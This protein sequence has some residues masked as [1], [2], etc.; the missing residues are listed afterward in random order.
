MF[1]LK[2]G[3]ISIL[4]LISALGEVIEMALKPELSDFF[5]NYNFDT[6]YRLTSDPREKIRF[7]AMIHLQEGKTFT[8]IGKNLKVDRHTVAEWLKRFEY[9]GVRGMGDKKRSGRNTTLPRSKEDRFKK[10]VAKLQEDREGGHVGGEDIRRM[11]KEVF[12][13]EY[14]LSG[15][16]DLLKRI[17]MVWITGRTVHPNAD[18]EAQNEFRDNFTEKAKDVLPADIDINKVDI[19]FQDEA[20]VGQRGT[21][22]RIWTEK[23]SRTGIV[24]Q[25]QFNSVYIFGAVCPLNDEAVG[26]VMPYADTSATETHLKIISQQVLEGRHALIIV[27]RA[28][29]HTTPKLHVPENISL[30]PLP[31]YSP[32]LNPTEQVWE[33]LRRNSL[34]NRCFKNYEAI[35]DA[36]CDAWNF[37]TAIP[38]TIKSLCSRKWALLAE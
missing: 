32:E 19:W 18:M 24:M 33:Q 9:E 11:L 23:G 21:A 37:F 38:G 1:I 7:L 6:P 12:G 3:L 26:I 10:E 17:G 15:V 27:D 31:P 22:T 35:V 16:Y 14:S 29:W 13:A 8:E 30:L 20:R 2:A 25:Q 36:C 5:I 34:S 28:A 4:I